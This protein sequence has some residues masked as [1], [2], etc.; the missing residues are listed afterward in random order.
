MSVFS[1]HAKEV[2]EARYLW[3]EE[4][5]ELLCYDRV[6]RT[7][8]QQE[9]DPRFWQNKFGEIIFNR[10]FIPGGRILRNAGR[11]KGNLANCFNLPLHDN[12][13]S[14]GEFIMNILILWKF[15]GGVGTFADLRPRGAELKTAGGSSSG[16]TSFFRAFDAIGETIEAGGQRRAAG[17]GLIDVSHPELFTFLDAKLQTDDADMDPELKAAVKAMVKLLQKQKDETLWRAWKLILAKLTNRISHFNLSVAINNGFLEAVERDNGWKLQYNK[18]VYNEMPAREIWHQICKRMVECAE[19]GLINWDNFLKN[20]SYYFAPISGTNACSELCLEDWGVCNLGSLALPRFIAQKNTN[21]KRLEEV[22]RI[23]VRFMDNVI[24]ANYYVLTQ[25]E[26]AA[27]NARRVG[28]GVMG[29]SDYLFLKEIRYGSDK[30]VAEVERVYRFIRDIVYDE[31]VKLAAEKGVFPKF[32]TVSFSKASFVRKLPQNLRMDIKKHGIRNC[33]LLA[34]APTGTTS[35]IS[36]CNSGVEALFA[37]AYRRKDNVS[38]RYYIHPLY[39]KYLHGEIKELPEWFVDA[40]DVTPQEHM[41]IVEAGLKFVD[42]NISKTINCPNGTTVE[43]VEDL[44]LNGI[45]NL[46]GC[47]IYVDGSRDQQVMYP[48]SEKEAK[49]L[50]KANTDLETV[51]DY[52]CLKDGICDL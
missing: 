6:G 44:L 52:Q 31:S 13:R 42:S 22:L 8:A 34:G 36:D 40:H 38:E 29:L 2:L 21:W 7:I 51:Q 43:E 32:D 10:E 25:I 39:E 47:T 5:W 27:K 49:K 4:T 24:D 48:L 37:K 35:L 16:L 18:V 1:D 23:A 45:W 28:I 46:K 50:I 9:K 33:T 26:E 15:G 19:P 30:S 14:I 3:Q 41:D 20:N 12:I 17:L 11:L